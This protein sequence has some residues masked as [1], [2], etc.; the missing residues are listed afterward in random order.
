MQS[1]IQTFITPR[2]GIGRV[3][4]D[5]ID[6]SISDYIFFMDDDLRFFH[7][8]TGSKK[9]S[10]SGPA[11]VGAMLIQMERWLREE[12]IACVGLSARY[13]NNWLP[14]EIFVENH[15]PCMAYGFDKRILQQNNIRFDDVEVCEDYHVILS[16]L[17]RGFKNRMSVIYACEDNGVN[18]DGGCS[19]YRTKEMVEE[20]METF[21]ALHK[22]YA[23]FRKTKGL[24]QGFDIGYEVSVQWKKAFK[25]KDLVHG[26]HIN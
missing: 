1:G 14:G 23:R 6:N 26:T 19:I 21:V 7:R 22:P 9:L 3:R 2:R 24:T 5:I 11:E 13:G 18:K 12:G 4:Q 8:P 16:L 17:R 10:K 25:D 15:R 20:S